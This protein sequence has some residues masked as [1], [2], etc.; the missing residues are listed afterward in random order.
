MRNAQVA[1]FRKERGHIVMRILKTFCTCSLGQFKNEKRQKSGHGQL[2]DDLDES[3]ANADATSAQKW[4]KTV[5]ISALATRGQKVGTFL[6]KALWD[7]FVRLNPFSRIV[8]QVV[9]ANEERI[10]G[11]QFQAVHL[12]VL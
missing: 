10:S 6:L 5:R 1:L 12:H 2:G 9:H 7:E 8:A 11:S 3:F 4:R